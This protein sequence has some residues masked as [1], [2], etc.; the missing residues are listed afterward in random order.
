MRTLS[1]R[2]EQLWIDLYERGYIEE[3]DVRNMQLW[4]QALENVGYEF[5]SVVKNRQQNIVLMGKF[6]Y[7]DIPIDSVVFWG[8]RFFRMW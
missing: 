8:E 1:E 6:N 2:M 3:E 7:G 5:P 4:L